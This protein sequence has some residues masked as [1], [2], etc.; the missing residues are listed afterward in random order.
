MK[1]TNDVFEIYEFVDNKGNEIDYDEF[2]EKY[3][4]FNK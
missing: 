2:I 3:C 4:Q 1:A